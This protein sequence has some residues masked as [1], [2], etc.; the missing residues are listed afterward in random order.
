MTA[1]RLACLQMNAADDMAA[2]VASWLTLATQAADAGADVIASP[3][4][5]SGM[6]AQADKVRL[7]GRPEADHPLL[8]AAREFAARRAKWVLLGSIG[9]REA[10][11]PDDRIDNRS[12]CIGPDGA[13]RARYDKIHMFDVDLPNGERYRESDSMRPGHAAPLVDL[14]WG[15][16]G[17][18]ICY[19][20]RFP[21]LYRALVQAGADFIAVPAAFT[22]HTGE[23]HWHVLLRARH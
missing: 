21:H 10:N 19:D 17:L 16:L 3:E 9:I 6:Y 7:G 18:T 4:N 5:S 20:L 12:Y 13:I 15:R 22:Q 11:A 14:P 2:N 1:F 8:T 23:R